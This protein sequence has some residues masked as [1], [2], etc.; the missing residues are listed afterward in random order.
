MKKIISVS[1]EKSCGNSRL[2]QAEMEYELD[3]CPALS[4]LLRPIC[5]VA[6]DPLAPTYSLSTPPVAGFSRALHLEPF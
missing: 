2:S 5:G 6:L 1:A 4:S 3:H